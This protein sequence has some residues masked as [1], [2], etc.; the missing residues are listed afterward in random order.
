VK[1]LLDTHTFLWT[2]LQPKKLPAES[3]R[4]LQDDGNEVFVSSVSL[5]EI[6][7]KFRLGRIDLID[8]STSELIPSAIQMGFVPI[9]L[10]PEEA[11]TQGAMKEDTHFD[12]FDR[13][14]IWQAI[15]RGLTLISGDKEFERFK[16][17]GLKLL[18]K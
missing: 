2:V 4:A 18:W 8:I 11:V 13:M 9:A 12:P 16:R 7:I 5:W 6:S 3:L 15:S 17:D 14:L 10:S 1:L